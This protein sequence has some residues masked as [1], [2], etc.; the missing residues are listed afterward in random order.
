[1]IVTI[2]INAY[3]YYYFCYHHLKQR[4][5]TGELYLKNISVP[6]PIILSYFLFF[7]FHFSFK[8][9]RQE[10]GDKLGKVLSKQTSQQLC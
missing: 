9:T 2:I 6:N 1:M 10:K 4:V 5:R 8:S 3:P 7:F